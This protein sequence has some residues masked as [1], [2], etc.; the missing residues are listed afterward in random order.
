M[1]QHEA[2]PK[3]IRRIV[4]PRGGPVLS[5]Q[6]FVNIGL[7]MGLIQLAN[8]FNLDAPEHLNYIRLAYLLSQLVS[9]TVILIIR[10]KVNESTDETPLRYNETK[11]MF[12]PSDITEVD[13]TVKDHDI[14]KSNEQLQQLVL[15]LGIMGFMHFQWGY[16]RPLLL[17]SVLGLRTLW[18]HP[19]VQIYIRGLPAT[20][21]L[22][23]PWKNR[24][25]EGAAPEPPTV[26][27]LKAQE[28]KALKKKLKKN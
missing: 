25:L 4:G 18:V 21:D 28:K 10:R 15:T 16:L 14:G 24:L 13:T 3:A 17:Q 2:T 23:R 22:K 26:K 7:A 19:L 6:L 12:D 27:E 20:G 1:P 5:T 9:L 8:R 11:N